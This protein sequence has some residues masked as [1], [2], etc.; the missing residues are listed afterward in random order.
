MG[1]SKLLGGIRY[2]AINTGA[3]PTQ[4]AELW[5]NGFLKIHPDFNP[6][7]YNKIQK[8]YIV[9]LITFICEQSLHA[10]AQISFN[11]Q[12][13]IWNLCDFSQIKKTKKQKVSQKVA[14]QHTTNNT[15]T[16]LKE[17]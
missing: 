16:M 14:P 8:I 11:S 7:N 9:N 3:L 17:I 6:M 5:F 15:A 10:T 2:P 4:K 13:N 12:I 1:S